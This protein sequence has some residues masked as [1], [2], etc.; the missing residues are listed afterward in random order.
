VQSSRLPV[1]HVH[2][3]DALVAEQE[4]AGAEETDVLIHDIRSFPV[5]S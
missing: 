4:L 1:L 5:K 3:L 2:K